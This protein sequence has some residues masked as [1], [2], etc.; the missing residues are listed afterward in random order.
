MKPMVVFDF[1]TTGLSPDEGARV[2]EVAAVIVQDGKI[3]SRYQSLMNAGVHVPAFITDLTGISNAMVQS[4]PSSKEVMRELCDF[5]G[6]LQIVAHNASFDKKFY[7]HECRLSGRQLPKHFACSML[8]ARRLF[9]NSPN[10]KLG[11]LV[12][13]LGISHSGQF[14]R[15]RSDAEMTAGLLLKIFERLEADYNISHPTHEILMRL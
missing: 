12:N 7:E 5:V 10:H 9:P 4:A 15:A 1:E 8:V 6:P 2:T 13:V 11:T 14:H 3:L